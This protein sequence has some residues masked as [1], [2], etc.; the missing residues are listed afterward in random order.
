[1]YD[2][3]PLWSIKKHNAPRQ[4]CHSGAI[5]S[6]NRNHHKDYMT[7][8]SSFHGVDISIGHIFIVCISL[9]WRGGRK[10]WPISCARLYR[11]SCAVMVRPQNNVLGVCFL[12]Y[13]LKRKTANTDRHQF[14]WCVALVL[15]KLV[16]NGFVLV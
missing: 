11:Y 14:Q 9:E 8:T 1:M 10:S 6:T 5:V 3:F 7:T 16:I 13:L 4:Q 2:F 15:Y 12:L